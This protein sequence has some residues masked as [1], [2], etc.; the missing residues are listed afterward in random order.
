MA[1]RTI[2]ERERAWLTE[3]LNAWGDEGIVTPNQA[4]RILELYESPTQVA[5]RQHSR[6]IF[7]LMG[8]SALL[9]GLAVLLLIG[10]NWEAMPRL[11]K[12]AIIFGMIAGT[13]AAGYHLRYRREARQASE[14]VYFL[15]CL[16]FGAGIFLIAQ[17]FHLN[18][19]YPDGI[20]WWAV[21]VLPFALC[22]DTLLLHGLLVALLG[23][24]A[25]TEILG[26]G[27]LGGWLFGRWS[28][29]PNAAYT[30]PLLALPGLL[31]GYRKLAP[32]TVSLYIPLLAWWVILQPFAWRWNI[33]PIFFI[34]CVG[35]LFLLLAECHRPGSPFA[36]PYRS[37]G[38]LLSI[39]VLVPLSFYDFNKDVLQ[40]PGEGQAGL[41]QTLAI[42]VLAA[43]VVAV[44]LYRNRE[45]P[46][47][48]F[49][50]QWLPLG[51]VLLMGFLSF[52]VALGAGSTARI[53]PLLPTILANLA[54][55]FTALWLIRLGLREDRGRPFAAG[56]ASFLIWAILRYIDLFGNYGGMLGASLMFFLCGAAL[57]GV[58]MY[59]RHRK[60]VVHV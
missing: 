49:R 48:F 17:I 51:I 33:N 21:G 20:W 29:M 14:L 9:V 12:L 19:H 37:Y 35:G 38:V 22:L 34:G 46:P 1:G 23:L 41:W 54:L 39:G 55:V 26:F 4:Q 45:S 30:L 58:A 6:A 50:R 8:V 7:T 5:D 52:W 43:A 44:A 10:Y 53:T 13:H 15:G 36:I 2:S 42:V 56:V 28:R 32:W 60:E 27:D 11:V 3:E 40:S 18:A 59:W 25:G 24:W 47:L 31:W 16:F 57:F